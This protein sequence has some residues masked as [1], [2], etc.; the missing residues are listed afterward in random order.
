LILL[1]IFFFSLV[2]IFCL[3]IFIKIITQKRKWYTKKPVNM[4]RTPGWAKHPVCKTFC[5][6]LKN[7]GFAVVISNIFH[8]LCLH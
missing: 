1:C 4:G 5:K 8:Q 3:F 2:R 6:M 7:K